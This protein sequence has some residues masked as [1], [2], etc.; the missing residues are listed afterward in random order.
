M[1]SKC[2]AF[3]RIASAELCGAADSPVRC[4]QL[5]AVRD[6]NAPLFFHDSILRHARSLLTGD[7]AAQGF[8]NSGTNRIP[9]GDDRSYSDR[10]QTESMH[11]SFNA[12][13]QRRGDAKGGCVCEGEP[14]NTIQ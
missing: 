8:D 1:S 11:L 10:F 3:A 14:R 7:F 5:A 13:T 2:S 4:R 9:S 6:H 12:K